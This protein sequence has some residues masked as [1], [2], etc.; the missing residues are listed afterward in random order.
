MVNKMIRKIKKIISYISQKNKLD[1]CING[2]M[3]DYQ[4]MVDFSNIIWKYTHKTHKGFGKC[5]LEI[6]RETAKIL[7]KYKL[8][9]WYC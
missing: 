7:R 5:G 3:E 8:P 2:T 4:F 6:E 1:I 9:S